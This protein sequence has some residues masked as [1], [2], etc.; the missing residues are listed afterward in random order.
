MGWEACGDQPC[1]K[2][3]SKLAVEFGGAQENGTPRHGTAPAD[4]EVAF[5]HAAQIAHQGEGAL[6]FDLDRL[7]VG[8]RQGKARPLQQARRVAQV[9]EG[10][11]AGAQS[12]IDLALGRRQRPTKLPEGGAAQQGAEEQS[13]GFQDARDL[14]QRARQVVH[15]VEVHGAQH[16]VEAAGR[17]GQELLVG[18]DGWPARTPREAAAEIGAHQLSN[19]RALAQCCRDLV[20][21]AAEIEGQRKDAADVRQA[22]D[23]PFGDLA[24]Q[25]IMTLPAA[26]GPFATLAQE[27]AVEHQQGVGAS[28][29]RSFVTVGM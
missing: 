7:A 26:R 22:V 20:A 27:G 24:F 12:A 21:V 11:D 16:Q 29:G 3:T 25:E 9:G 23:Q 10:R 2:R 15:P 8:H 4:H 6:V 28:Q 13:V 1:R 14:D 5:A 18:D 17:K 19:D